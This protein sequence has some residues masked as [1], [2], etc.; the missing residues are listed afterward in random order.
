MNGYDYCTTEFIVLQKTPYSDSSLILIGI[1]P[2]EG[3]L[4]LL[5]KGAR[6]LQRKRFSQVDILQLLEVSYR[7]ANKNMHIPHSIDI[8]KDHREIATNY[9][10]YE[11]ACWL[12]RFALL[13]VIPDVPHP[14]FFSAVKIALERLCNIADQKENNQDGQPPSLQAVITAACVVY[15]DEN[16]WLPYYNNDVKRQHQKQLLI[17]FGENRSAYPKLTVKTWNQLFNWMKSLCHYHECLL[18]KKEPMSQ[19]E[20]DSEPNLI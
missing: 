4:R 17:D 1:T 8:C 16:G 13:N 10:V 14:R 6:R 11:N 3:I 20:S 15:L 7:P 5:A 18:P 9:L 19:E 2:T 12:I